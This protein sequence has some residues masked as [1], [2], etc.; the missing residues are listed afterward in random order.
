MDSTSTFQL[1]MK[2]L[3]TGDEQAADE[4]FKRFT[5]RLLLL[6]RSRLNA[7]LQQKV[8][9]EDILQ[10]VY[11]SFFR[12]NQSDDFDLESWDGLWALLVTITV[13][14]CAKQ[15]RYFRGKKRDISREDAIDLPTTENQAT[16]GWELVSREP[17]SEQAVLLTEI[18]D[19]LM[20]PFDEQG[21]TMISMRLQGFR[22]REISQEV[23]RSERTVRRILSRARIELVELLE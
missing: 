19:H 1:V 2:R 20:R 6:A 15:A 8:D 10:S 17:T 23:N 5:G 9:P 21:Q 16:G 18:V 13:R 4:I 7:R 3:G 12:R 14:K 22:E 11:Q